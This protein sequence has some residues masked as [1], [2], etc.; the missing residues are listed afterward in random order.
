MSLVTLWR[1]TLGRKPR[2]NQLRFYER[3]SDLPDA[4]GAHEL[5]I[6]GASDRPKWAVFDCPCATGHRIMLN[7]QRSRRPCWRLDIDVGEPSL[8]PSVD[9]RDTFRCHFWLTRGQV[10][11]APSR[12]DGRRVRLLAQDL[13]H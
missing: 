6:V 7:L 11:W 12:R 4:L 2:I 13:A 10:H 8:H 1:R 3:Q 5:A 9:V